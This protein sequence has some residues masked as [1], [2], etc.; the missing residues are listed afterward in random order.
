MRMNVARTLLLAAATIA[1]D[2]GVAQYGPPIFG[3]PTPDDGIVFPFAPPIDKT[4]RYRFARSHSSDGRTRAAS[5]VYALRFERDGEGYLLWVEME[6]L[7]PRADGTPSPIASQVEPMLGVPFAVEL[8]PDGP[9]L[10]IRNQPQLWGRFLESMARIRA[11]LD[12]AGAPGDPGREAAAQLAANF[13]TLDPD[14]QRDLL[15]SP[16]Q[17]IIAFAGATLA[18][19]GSGV[20][21]LDGE[22]ATILI[23]SR[24][25][26]AAFAAAHGIQDVEALANFGIEEST[27]YTVSR[28]SGLAHA[29]QQERRTGPLDGPDA[30]DAVTRLDISL[31]WQG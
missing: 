5:Y 12:A 11:Q 14:G 1:P 29:V 27:R 28:S 4:L 6:S 16:I 30:D 13:A 31:L 15:L 19:E 23:T 7:E 24:S 20:V 3:A 2:A 8:S 22:T 10:G 18:R 9:A 25:S 17:P 26:G 21:A